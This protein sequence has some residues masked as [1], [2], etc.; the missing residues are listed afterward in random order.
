MKNIQLWTLLTCLTTLLD[1]QH[2]LVIEYLKEENQILREHI[3][4]KQDTK[5]IL[6]T[7]SQ[8]RRLAV[9]A[10]ALGRTL[11]SETTDLFSPATI[12][13]WYKKLI[14]KKYDGSANRSGGRTKV[15]QEKIDLVLKMSRENPDWGAGRIRNYMNYLGYKIGKTTVWR[16]MEDHGL[17]PDPEV[18]KKGD[19]NKF[20]SSHLDVLAATDF[21]SVELLTHKGLVRCMVLFIIDI[22][23]RRVHI[24][25]IK[26]APDGQWIKQV[27]K[28][29]TDCEDGFLKGKRYLIHDRDSL[30]TREFDQLIKAVGV[31]VVKTVKQSP[32]LNAYAERFVQTI[33]TECLNHLVLSSPEQLEYVIS[34]FVTYYHRE[35][36]HESL[37]GGMIEPWPQDKDGPIVQF[38]RLGGLLKSYRRVKQAA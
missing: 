27:A 3:Y 37:G 35:R 7:D 29:I 13:G 24:A 32:N 33:K 28:N 20:I 34:E 1:K 26:A 31:D 11:L 6:L 9:K 30:F 38:E 21:F 22:G 12:I 8:R 17:N 4:K 19:W 14:A 10:K 23:S 18:R 36:P 2:R 25:G 15:S 16:I 5:R